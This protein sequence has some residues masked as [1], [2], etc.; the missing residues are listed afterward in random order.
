VLPGEAVINRLWDDG[1]RW[2]PAQ[3]LSALAPGGASGATYA[4][5][6]ALLT[7]YIA[8]IGAATLLL[9]RRRDV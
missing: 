2:L 4:H 3:L 6:L 5:A 7:V 1:D 8:V 9:F